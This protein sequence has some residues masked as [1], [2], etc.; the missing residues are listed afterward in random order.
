MHDRAEARPLA[1]DTPTPALDAPLV[2]L[3]G[4]TVREGGL[5]Q[6]QQQQET[7]GPAAAA[8]AASEASAR[9]FASILAPLEDAS[10]GKRLGGPGLELCRAAFR[11]NPHGFRLC[12]AQALER[13]T[14]NALG[15]L[16]RMVGDDDH[17]DVLPPAAPASSAFENAE[18]WVR[19]VGRQLEPIDFADEL[20]RLFPEFDELGRQR[21]TRL[22]D[23][24]RAEAAR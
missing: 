4:E 10:G 9:E 21:L 15:L 17:R 20:P 22:Y 14:R 7:E 13:A 11:E 12:A 5:Q 19:R 6:L 2:E 1:V 18:Q 8:A 3:R 24:L 23:H 16:V